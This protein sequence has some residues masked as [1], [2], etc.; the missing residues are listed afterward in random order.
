M[1]HPEKLVD[2][3]Y[4]SV[5]ETA[6]RGKATVAALYGWRPRVSYFEGCS[7]GGRMSFMEAQRFPND[8]DGIIAG[9]PG[10]NRTDVA[11]QTLGMTQATHVNQEKFIPASKYPRFTGLRWTCDALDGLKDGL[12]CDPS[13]CPFDPGVLE[14]KDADGP[15]C[16]TAAANRRGTQDLR[17]RARSERR[18]GL[19]SRTREPRQ[20]GSVAG[21]EPHSMYNDLLRFIVMKIRMGLHEAGYDPGSGAG[22]E[23]GRRAVS[24]VDGPHAVREPWRQVPHLSRLGRQ[25]IP[26]QDS[27]DYYNVVYRRW[28]R[29]RSPTPCG[30]SWCREWDTA[31]A[32]TANDSTCCPC[33]SNGAN[34]ERPPRRSWPWS[35]AR[36]AWSERGRSVPTL[37]SDTKGSGSI[38]APRTSCVP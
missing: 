32:A 36:A 5:D 15:S 26:P 9:A 22:A 35:S 14:C 38:D 18:R 29:R 12:I 7:G 28:A 25:N 19:R 1:G 31:A 20:W 17:A 3:G 34:W 13:N 23:G 33:S 4:R 27:V 2:F 11:F 10:Y 8:F 21:N 30:S 24:H 16:L 6:V 37:R